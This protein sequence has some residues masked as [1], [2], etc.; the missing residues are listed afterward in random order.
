MRT[1]LAQCP[2]HRHDRNAWFASHLYAVGTVEEITRIYVAIERDPRYKLHELVQED[3]RLVACFSDSI[4]RC[5]LAKELSQRFPFVRCVLTWQYRGHNAGYAIFAAG[6]S[7][8]SECRVPKTKSKASTAK[9]ENQ[10]RA[11]AALHLSMPPHR[12]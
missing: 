4:P 2:N 3:C 8:I 7:E 11:F 6:E 12:P 9:L 1:D 10:F 5:D